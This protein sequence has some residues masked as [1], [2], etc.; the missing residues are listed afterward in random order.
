M[1]H[2][3]DGNNVVPANSLP[4][5]LAIPQTQLARRKVAHILCP[6]LSRTWP[7]FKIA[8]NGHFIKMSQ[9]QR[10]PQASGRL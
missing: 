4:P 9:R 1:L 7:I 6:Y 3:N 2:Y 5:S 10:C 8:F